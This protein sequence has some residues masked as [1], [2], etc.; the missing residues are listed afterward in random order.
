MTIRHLPVVGGPTDATGRLAKIAIEEHF[1]DPAQVQPHFGDGFS[2]EFVQEGSSFGGFNMA[3]DAARWIETA[4][5]SENDR[6]K[7]CH[8]NAAA[9]FGLRRSDP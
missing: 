6:R 9:L 8:G 5:I 7:I 2:G 3:T 1:V 4:P